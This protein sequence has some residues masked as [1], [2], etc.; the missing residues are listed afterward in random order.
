MVNAIFRW[1]WGWHHK[2][3]SMLST[4]CRLSWMKTAHW[5]YHTYTKVLWPLYRSTFVSWHPQL[6]NGRLC[7]SKVSLPVCPCWWQLVHSHRQKMLEL[8]SMVL[9]TPFPYY[10]QILC[11]RKASLVAALSQL[12]HLSLS[13]DK[14][15]NDLKKNCKQT[16]CHLHSSVL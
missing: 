14:V 2:R 1:Q 13:Y 4:G 7:W 3:H 6:R 8:S 11:Q 5:S 10:I 16:P 9:P 12:C 15:Q